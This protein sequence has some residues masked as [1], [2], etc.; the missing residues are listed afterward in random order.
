MKTQC[1]MNNQNKY[2]LTVKAELSRLKRVLAGKV[3]RCGREVSM[4]CESSN[5]DFRPGYT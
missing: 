2:N 5:F 4:H 3:C 1:S